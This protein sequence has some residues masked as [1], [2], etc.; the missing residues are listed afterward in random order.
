MRFGGWAHKLFVKRVPDQPLIP[1]GEKPNYNQEWVDFQWQQENDL[2]TCQ[3]WAGIRPM[4]QASAWCWPNSGMF[5]TISFSNQI[6]FKFKYHIPLQLQP[7]QP[8]RSFIHRLTCTI[9]MT[10]LTQLVSIFLFTLQAAILNIQLVWYPLSDKMAE[11]VPFR[12]P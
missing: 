5:T 6:P 8:L 1:V 2:W 4:L 11:S 7:F 12:V 10:T 9:Y 3:N